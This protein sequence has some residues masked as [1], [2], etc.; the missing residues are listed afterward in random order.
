MES[1]Y[2]VIKRLTGENGCPWDKNQTPETLIHYLIEESYEL[3]DAIVKGDDTD[4]TDEAG[5]VLFQ[6]L[7]LMYLLEKNGRVKQ[8][9]IISGVCTKMERRHP[10][11]F[12][13]V[14][15]NSI[16]DV[17]QNW[18]RIK[19]GEKK[20]S[21]TSVLDA[22]PK[23][24]PP[25]IRAHQVSE[26]TVKQGFDWDTLEGVMQKVEEEW[27]EFKTAIKSNDKEHATLEFGD[28]LFTLV[29]VARFAK[30][31]PETALVKA[32]QKFE[33]RYRHMESL[34]EE[35]GKTLKE[36]SRQTIDTLWD[37]SKKATE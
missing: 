36:A 26:K 13:D 25:L 15:V 16:D 29:N 32:T 8:K 6:L 31:S 3:F 10:H 21:Y 7:F 23:N 1:I 18:D 24:L 35:S 22:V 11:V 14:S 12:G 37:T 2:H 9:D 28:L 34:F 5:D 33:K 17:N 4:I 20:V 27:S 19:Q 30:F